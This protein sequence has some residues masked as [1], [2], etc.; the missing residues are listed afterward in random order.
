MS[1]SPGYDAHD[2]MEK[3]LPVA[4]I[5]AEYEYLE[6]HAAIHFAMRDAFPYKQ[7]VSIRGSRTFDTLFLELPDG[8]TREYWF[9][10]TS[11]FGK[12]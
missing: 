3:A 11:F 7:R 10:I 12:D 4:C 8:S 6:C 9:D 1:Y 2:S 5:E